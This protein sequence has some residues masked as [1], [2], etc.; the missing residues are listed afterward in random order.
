MEKIIGFTRDNEII[1]AD[2]S[3]ERVGNNPEP[4]FTVSFD[5]SEI[6]KADDTIRDYDYMYNYFEDI[7]HSYDPESVLN[8]CDEFDCPP[9]DL[10]DKMTVDAINND[11]IG[12]ETLDC[13]LYPEIIEVDEKDYI[14][15]STSCG[16]HDTRDEVEEFVDKKLYD[17]IHTLWD[18]YHLKNIEDNEDA[19]NLYESVLDRMAKIDDKKVII[20]YIKRNKI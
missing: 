10:A 11:I 7:R 8:W 3:F 6:K 1:V 12:M 13:S 4:D 17:D 14:F 20:N 2:V 9:S 16:Q 19:M 18:N 5:L 15:V